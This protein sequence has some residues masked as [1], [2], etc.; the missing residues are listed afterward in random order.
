MVIYHLLFEK[1]TISILLTHETIYFLN[2]IIKQHIKN[3]VL[4]SGKFHS[5]CVI[6]L[7]LSENLNSV[8][9]LSEQL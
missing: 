1:T 4:L 7:I 9:K 5:P 3:I 2:S 6:A 8:M